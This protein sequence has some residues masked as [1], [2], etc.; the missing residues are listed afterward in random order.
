MARAPIDLGSG[1]ALLDL[2]SFGRAA[3]LTLTRKQAQTI[4]YTGR[5]NSN[6]LER[7]L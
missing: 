5:I 4:A 1:G 6:I 2:R 7:R 3:R